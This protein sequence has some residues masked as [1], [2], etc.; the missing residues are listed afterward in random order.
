M[1]LGPELIGSSGL[2]KYELLIDRFK[3]IFECDSLLIYHYHTSFIQHDQC[4][5][6]IFHGLLFLALLDSLV[7]ETI[8]TLFDS[9]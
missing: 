6:F 3:S 7:F 2:W 9:H 5:S 1:S 4:P 8:D